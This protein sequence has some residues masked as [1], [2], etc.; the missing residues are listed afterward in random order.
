MDTKTETKTEE[1]A[2]VKLSPKLEAVRELLRQWR[3]E[4]DP[5]EQRE[6]GEYLRKVLEEDRFTVR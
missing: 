1:N 6:T 2:P 5:E 3:E 4:G